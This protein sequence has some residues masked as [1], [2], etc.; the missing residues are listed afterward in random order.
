MQPHAS[1]DLI[2]RHAT[3]LVLVVDALGRLSW[4]S[5]SINRMLGYTEQQLVGTQIITLVHPD[6]QDR[7]ARAITEPGAEAGDADYR[8]RHHDGSWRHLRLVG[9]CEAESNGLVVAMRDVTDQLRREAELRRRVRTE[10]LLRRISLGFID[11]APADVEMAMQQ[12]LADIARF[13][14]A[15]RAWLVTF[16]HSARYVTGMAQWCAPNIP[17]MTPGRQSIPFE[18]LASLLDPLFEMHPVIVHSVDQLEAF[19]PLDAAAMRHEGVRS[20]LVMPMASRGRLAA[21]IGF[22]TVTHDRAWIDD[23]LAILRSASGLFTQALAR[24]RAEARLGISVE[25]FNK[26]FA[27][28]PIGLALLDDANRIERANPA[29]C[30]MLQRSEEDLLNKHLDEL[31]SGSEDAAELLAGSAQ[32]RSGKIRLGEGP[33]ASWIR[34]TAQGSANDP[35]LRVVMLE[36]VTDERRV[37]AALE[38]SEQRLRALLDNLPDPVVRVSREGHQIMGNRAARDI[39]TDEQESQSVFD[40]EVNG[41]WSDGIREVFAAGQ[42]Y[43]VEYASGEDESSPAADSDPDAHDVEGG[44]FLEARMVP[45]FAPD[46]TVDSV[47]IVTRDIT[48]QRHAEGELA[49]QALHDALTSLPNRK[50]F[51]SHLEHA[52]ASLH[53]HPSTLAVLF[54]DLDRFK[55]V[56]DTLG[57]HIGDEV[58]SAA[59]Q[60]IRGALRPED[61]VARL[62]GDEFV[63]LLENLRDVAEA[64]QAAQRLQRALNVPVQANG[65]LVEIQASIGIALT[66]D[67]NSDPQELVRRADTAML[68]AKA[69]G[70]GRTEVFD[71]VLQA[72]VTSRLQL[73]AELRE[74]I[75]VGQLEVHYQP[76]VDLVTGETVG[77][78]ALVRWR[79]PTRGLIVASEFISLANDTGLIVAIGTQVLMESCRVVHSLNRL[80]PGRPLVC[81]VNVSLREIGHTELLHAVTD[82]LEGSG[83]A[84]SLLCLEIG[85]QT[86]MA[87]QPASMALLSD[88][89]H[90][91]VRVT[92][93]DFGTGVSSISALQRFPLTALKIDGA[94]VKGLPGDRPAQAVVA[95]I[96]AL[97]RA[98]DLD[99]IAEGI[100]TEEQAT[101]LVRLGCRTGQGFLYS[102]AT[103]AASFPAW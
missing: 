45:E 8:V 55:N 103:P 7:A 100:E 41:A 27:S 84:P 99:V 38:S 97:A 31:L 68:R 87:D 54:F 44:R 30:A 72:Q 95:S 89:D 49:R 22:E 1:N 56:N 47:L 50:L 15:D 52:V 92:V 76:E 73:E 18:R 94:F 46:G 96:V 70:R 39:D 21:A 67:G 36:D 32:R 6:E 28:A 17:D 61:V 29:F 23:D 66:T 75:D 53:R 33:N 42:P 10:D 62:G 20:I 2:Q 12:A 24:Q 93:D 16:D 11:L 59:A 74:A 19:S 77:V 69:G 101:M 26:S 34:L 13:C 79:H 78:E 90:L 65:N 4:V 43:V 40:A 91:G 5:P 57:H 60:R 35:A 25:E 83:L 48:D 102:A 14:A 63:V 58:L 81:H 3:D 51:M 71:E 86:L 37:Q 85:E 80:R 98:L 82:A 9:Q 88:L 64:V